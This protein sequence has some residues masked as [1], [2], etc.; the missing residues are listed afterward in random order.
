MRNLLNGSEQSRDL[1]EEIRAHVE[2]MAEE[3]MANGMDPERARREARME[4]GGIEQ[5]KEE[6]RSNRAGAW[7][8]VLAQDVRFGV[9][10]LIKNP[11]FTLVA[12]LALALGIGANTAMFSIAVIVHEEERSIA[13]D[14][15]MNEGEWSLRLGLKGLP[16]AAEEAMIARDIALLERTGGRLHIAHLSTAGAVELVRRAKSRGLP[17]SAEATPHHFTLTEA[18]VNG[19]NT[20]AKMNPP[21]RTQRD[22]DAVRA[23]L[24]DGTIEVIATDHAP[25]HRDEKDVEFDQAANGVVGLETALPLALSLTQHGVGLDSII[26]ALSTNPARVL[27]V[28]GGTLRPGAAADVTIIDPKRS[29]SVE[30]SQF[31]SKGRSTPFAGMQLQGRAVMTIVGGRIVYAADGFGA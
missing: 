8:D 25:H 30:P 13:A 19:Y 9:R 11:G 24:A 5:V 14:G 27:G 10:V 12:V 20:D 7:L 15:V 23:G 22:V 28:N 18:A 21:L 17:V 2:L 6:V 3:K 16:A 1:D 29:W 31:R 26:A 4:A